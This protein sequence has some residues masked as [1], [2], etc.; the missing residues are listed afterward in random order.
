MVEVAPTPRLYGLL[1]EFASTDALVDGARRA[2]AAG[3]RRL[4]AYSP[5]P[6]EG[7]AEAI[8]FHRTGLP[9]LVFAGGAFGCLLGFLLQYWVSVEAYPLNVGG[10]PLASWP[11]FVIVSFELTILMAA[12][13]AVIGMLVLNGLPRPHHPLFDCERFVL[14]SRDRFFLCIEAEDER[15]D[16]VATRRFL[17]TLEPVEVVEVAS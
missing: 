1:A 13:S 8:G 3:Y 14:A 4:D 2:Y 17:E 11:S 16:P 15:F 5:M 6:I 9:V 10:R 12:L 7:L